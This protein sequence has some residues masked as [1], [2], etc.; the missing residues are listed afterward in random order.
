MATMVY[1][2]IADP[3]TGQKN[4]QTNK[5]QTLNLRHIS[6]DLPKVNY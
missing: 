2:F 1:V 5:Q 6:H 4:K 3:D